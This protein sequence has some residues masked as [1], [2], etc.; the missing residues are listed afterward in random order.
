[1]TA[2]IDQ[3]RQDAF[4]AA[5]EWD[6]YSG[7]GYTVAQ[8]AH[9]RVHAWLRTGHLIHLKRSGRYGQPPARH[10]PTVPSERYQ[11]LYGP[12]SPITAS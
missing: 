4:E 6:R 10:Y 1:M 12:Q 3:Q 2:I 5:K 11:Q 7:H 8:H 9:H